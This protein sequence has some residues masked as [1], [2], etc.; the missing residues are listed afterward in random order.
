MN[1]RPRQKPSENARRQAGEICEDFPIYS[2]HY[3]TEDVHL[4][5][6]GL[7]LS[8]NN[9]SHERWHGHSKDQ[10]KICH[11][12]SIHPKRTRAHPALPHQEPGVWDRSSGAGMSMRHQREDRGVN[13]QHGASDVV[14][15][16]HPTGVDKA[17]ES[18]NGHLRGSAVSDHE[19]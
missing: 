5:I 2:F 19:T 3:S 7:D 9:T 13:L 16:V 8:L 12:G 18:Q 10:R 6:N 17:T 1:Q 11:W 4:R 15:R 14:A